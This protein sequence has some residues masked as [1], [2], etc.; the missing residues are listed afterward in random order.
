[1]TKKDRFRNAEKLKKQIDLVLIQTS[2][3]AYNSLCLWRLLKTLK[4][5]ITLKQIDYAKNQIFEKK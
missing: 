4:K 2:F 5:K 1:M 3:E